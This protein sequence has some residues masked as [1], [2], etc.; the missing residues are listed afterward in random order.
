MKKLNLL[1]FCLALL[2]A[3]CQKT[4]EPPQAASESPT[5]FEQAPQ[6][7]VTCDKCRHAIIDPSCCCVITVIEGE[8]D[9]SCI[10]LCGTTS[11][12]PDECIRRCE[13]DSVCEFPVGPIH[14]PN[15][16]LTPGQSHTY[17][18]AH[19]HSYLVTNCGQKKVTVNIKCGGAAAQYTLPAGGVQA[20]LTTD[21]CDAKPCP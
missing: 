14:E 10:D 13:R 17:C 1:L 8:A 2:A 4:Q 9:G 16:I 3:A 20:M 5:I 21:R 11:P 7:E 6:C 12:L 15:I 19:W 18:A